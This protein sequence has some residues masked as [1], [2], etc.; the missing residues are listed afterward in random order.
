MSK[1]FDALRCIVCVI[2]TA[3]F[4]VG[5][6]GGGGGGSPNPPNNPPANPPNGVLAPTGVEA[7]AGH[8]S[9]TLT[10]NAVTSATAYRVYRSTTSG[11]L[12]SL[13]GSPTETSYS[14]AGLTNGTTYYYV[15]RAHDGTSES[16]NSQVVSATPTAVPPAIPTGIEA[17]SLNDTITVKW[18]AVA[19]A[20]S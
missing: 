20:S 9:V 5:C 13:I 2:F 1:S 15:V 10:W 7:Q 18:T 19:N 12:Y 16:P 14:D 6:G 4:L 8:H 17:T 11:G 3:A